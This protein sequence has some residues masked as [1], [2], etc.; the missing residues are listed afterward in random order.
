MTNSG[1]TFHIWQ[2]RVFLMRTAKNQTKQMVKCWSTTTIHS[3]LASVNMLNIVRQFSCKHQVMDHKCGVQQINR[4]CV[5]KRDLQFITES[6]IAQRLC[7]NYDLLWH[8]R[9]FARKM[10]LGGFMAFHILFRNT[11][12]LNFAP[13]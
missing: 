1:V 13:Q 2:G 12:T 5:A 7:L 4:E 8:P 3:C 11:H 10:A 6:T 9:S